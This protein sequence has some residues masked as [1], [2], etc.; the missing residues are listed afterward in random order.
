MAWLLLSRV[1]L[2]WHLN[3]GSPALLPLSTKCAAHGLI[4]VH[5]SQHLLM[6]L[7]TVMGKRFFL[8]FPH[9]V[10]MGEARMRVQRGKHQTLLVLHPSILQTWTAPFSHTGSRL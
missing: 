4:A 7:E 6:Q 3:K 1:D 9:Q 10:K 2:E 5:P 8:F